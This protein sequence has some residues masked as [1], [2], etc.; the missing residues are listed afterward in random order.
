MADSPGRTAWIFLTR[1]MSRHEETSSEQGR[2]DAMQRN[3]TK[4][5]QGAPLF[6]PVEEPDAAVETYPL[7][8]LES[9]RVPLIK[10]DK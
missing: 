6:V 3:A 10:G 1:K 9:N 7:R 8:F 2:K 4:L 5:L